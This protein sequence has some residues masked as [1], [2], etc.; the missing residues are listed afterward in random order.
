MRGV[1]IESS[2]IDELTRSLARGSNDLTVASEMDGGDQV[3]AVSMIIDPPSEPPVD[4][5]VIARRRD[6]YSCHQIRTAPVI[7][8]SDSTGLSGHISVRLSD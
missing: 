8:C 5:A 3:D 4:G 7:Y 1:M 2:L 6:I